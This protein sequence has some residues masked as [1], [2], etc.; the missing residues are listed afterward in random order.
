MFIRYYVINKYLL[1]INLNK[2]CRLKFKRNFGLTQ[3]LKFKKDNLVEAF[4]YSF[5]NFSYMD[6]HSIVDTNTQ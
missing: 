5:Y 4:K 3:T 6:N 1:Q 2:N